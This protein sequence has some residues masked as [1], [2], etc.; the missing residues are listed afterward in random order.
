MILDGISMIDTVKARMNYL[1]VRQS[2]IAQNVANADT[3]G[4][5]AKDLAPFADNFTDTL[6]KAAQ[7]AKT[8]TAHLAANP[9]TQGEAK[10]DRQHEGW[11]LAPNGN[12]IVL[13][14]EMIKA[15]ETRAAYELS[16]LVFS[17]HVA[18]T[19]AAFGPR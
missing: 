16:N 17:K 5:R 1:Q 13:E 11:E 14:Q 19:R 3:P 8:N 6:A 12:S 15:N 9:Q 10:L 7:M 2:L 4:V 18:M